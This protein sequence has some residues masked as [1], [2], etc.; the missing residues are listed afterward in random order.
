MLQYGKSAELAG[1][2][3]CLPHILEYGDKLE[4]FKVTFGAY[5]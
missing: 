5:I 3:V 2:Q 1:R 4:H